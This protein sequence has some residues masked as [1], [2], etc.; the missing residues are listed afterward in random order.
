MNDRLT[1]RSLADI[2]SIQT[3]LDKECAEQFIEILS[4]HITEHIMRDK[5]IKVTGLGTFKIILVS[6][7]ESV[8]IHTQERFVIPAH[9]KLSFIPDKY[10]KEQVNRPFAIYEPIETTDEIASFKQFIADNQEEDI[11]DEPFVT[12]EPTEASLEEPLDELL[13]AS[14]EDPLDESIEAPVVIDENIVSIDADSDSDETFADLIESISDDD[15]LLLEHEKPP[16]IHEEVSADEIKMSDFEP[17]AEGK[18]R[19]KKTVTAPFWVLFILYPLLIV[20]GTGFATYTFLTHNSKK[21]P[22]EYEEKPLISTF[23]DDSTNYQATSITESD[24][25]NNSP[26]EDETGLIGLNSDTTSLLNDTAMATPS[27]SDSTQKTTRSNINWFDTTPTKDKPEPK[28]IANKPDQNTVSTRQTTTPAPSSTTPTN[29]AKE[30]TI[31]AVIQMPPGESLIDQ[32]IKFYGHRLMWVY[33]YEHNKEL[34][35]DN[36]DRVPLGL[37]IRLPSPKTY[38]FDPNNPASL[39]K[40]SKKQSELLKWK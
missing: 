24:S 9:H 18:K 35:G 28:R 21:E 5:S 25:I 2:L 19:K 17:E 11:E 40:A 3:G 6:E 15:Y 27:T 7:R 30:K 29:E 20:F 1:T 32:A 22:I 36:P 23:S 33:I 12:N 37:I 26:G 39:E 14:V 8:H 10:L 16:L 4:T 31:P 13:E 34:I 38:G